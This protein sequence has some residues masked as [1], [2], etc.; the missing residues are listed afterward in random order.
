VSADDLIAL[1]IQVRE[2]AY[3]P[4]S[5]YSVGCA[6][7][8]DGAIYAGANVENASYGLALCAERAAVAAA[9]AAG[10]RAIEEVAVVTASSPPA[11]PC[12][13]CLQTLTEFAADPATVRVHLVNPD[14]ERRTVTLAECLPYGF[15]RDQLRR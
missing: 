2:R 6:L 7:V 3:A 14:G 13:M 5:G 12:G 11:A 10:A 4:Y 8:A 15:R 9:V 1:A